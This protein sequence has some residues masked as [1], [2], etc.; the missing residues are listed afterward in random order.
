MNKKMSRWIIISLFTFLMMIIPFSAKANASNKFKKGN[1]TY[2]ISKNYLYKKTSSGKKSKIAFLGANTDILN[3]Y[4]DDLYYSKEDREKFTCKICTINLKTSKKKTKKK[5][6]LESVYCCGNSSDR[7]YFTYMPHG[8]DTIGRGL[9]IYK[10]DC[11]TQK[12]KKIVSDTYSQNTIFSKKYLY[13]VASDKCDYRIKI[14]RMTLSN[15]K[16]KVIKT[17]K[18][19]KDS[20]ILWIE[21]FNRNSIKLYYGDSEDNYQYKTFRY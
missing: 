17:C 8:G 9:D 6:N 14:C 12:A 2:Y 7:R 10:Y 11:K 1:T 19:P 20:Y 21:K 15:E 18:L 5:L 13:Y 4:K 3:I 16:K